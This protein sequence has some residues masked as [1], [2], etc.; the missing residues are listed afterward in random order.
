VI[1]TAVLNRMITRART[2]WERGSTAMTT[3]ELRIMPTGS[4]KTTAVVLVLHGGK[5]RGQRSV[6]PYRLAYQRMLPFARAIHRGG[7]RDGVAVWCLRNRVEGWNAPALDPVVDARWA[8]ARIRAEHPGVPVAVVGHS[9]GGRVVL[10]VA[11]DP[12]VVAVC[13]LAPWTERDEPVDALKGR[14]VLIAHGDYD[15]VTDPA[16]S[17]DFAVRARP[18][19]KDIARFDVHG[20][21]HAM[22]RRAG[23]WTALV[24]GFVLAGLGFEPM[25]AVVAN[26]FTRPAP[27]G[28]AVPL[29]KGAG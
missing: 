26:A 29:A 24:R 25:P 13:A 9:M 22:L 6:R 27:A 21:G 15:R 7:R 4:A 23:D 20:D 5:E 28:L 1:V 19:A 8:L 12:A 14:T 2:K 3:P 17:Y 11:D 10:R 18:I 16:L